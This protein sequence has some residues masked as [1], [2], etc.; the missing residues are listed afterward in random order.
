MRER[1][2]DLLFD[3]FRIW[4]CVNGHLTS[5]FDMFR[6]WQCVNGHLTCHSCQ[7]Q[8]AACPLC[9]SPFSNTRKKRV[10][11]NLQR[12]TSKSPQ[13]SNP[14][15]LGLIPFHYCKKANFL[16]EPVRKPQIRKF[17]QNTSKKYC[18]TLSQNSPKIRLYGRFL[19]IYLNF[20]IIYIL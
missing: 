3:L 6:I 17:L 8:T 7:R 14:Q 4:Q 5:F 16:G 1:S 20:F 15:I 12:L 9:R 19:C 13:I 2:P 18:T 11:N 10:S